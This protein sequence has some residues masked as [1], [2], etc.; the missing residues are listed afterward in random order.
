MPLGRFDP[1][2]GSFAQISPFYSFPGY[3]FFD[4]Y[5]AYNLNAYANLPPVYRPFPNFPGVA[6]Q[7]PLGAP[8]APIPASSGTQPEQSTLPSE[9]STLNV[10][11]YS[12]KDSAIPNVPPPPLPQGGLKSDDK[13]E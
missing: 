10:L 2:H 12:S 11:N 3:R 1:V 9:P 5:D 8:S 7:I 4:P 13:S 6:P